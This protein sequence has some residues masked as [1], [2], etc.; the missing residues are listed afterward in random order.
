M[1]FGSSENG[2]PFLISSQS[3]GD[4]CTLT[5]K[6]IVLM[7]PIGFKSGFDRFFFPL[8]IWYC[9]TCLH[10]SLYCCSVNWLLADLLPFSVAE[11]LMSLWFNCGF[12]VIRLMAIKSSAWR[13]YDLYAESLDIIG[14]AWY[15]LSGS[16]STGVVWTGCRWVKT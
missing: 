3:T 1:P 6:S 4:F 7:S 9:L 2:I 14:L 12:V 13:R 8:A 15:Q 11:S 5:F 10:N 16:P